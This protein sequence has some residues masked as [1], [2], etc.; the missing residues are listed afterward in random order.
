MHKIGLTTLAKLNKEGRKILL[1][2]RVFLAKSLSQT[3]GKG[4]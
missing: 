3:E 2:S 1:N 4:F